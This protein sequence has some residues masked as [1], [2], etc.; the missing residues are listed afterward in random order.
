MLY[1][2]INSDLFISFQKNRVLYNMV[3]PYSSNP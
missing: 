2:G 3:T 1:F